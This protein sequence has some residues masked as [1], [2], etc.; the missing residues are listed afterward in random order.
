MNWSWEELNQRARRLNVDRTRAFR[1]LQHIKNVFPDRQAAWET[2][3]YYLSYLEAFLTGMLAPITLGTLPRALSTGKAL[4]GVAITGAVD[5]GRLYLQQTAV[6][7]CAIHFLHNI[8]VCGM[9]GSGKTRLVM[10]LGY[11]CRRGILFDREGE[12]LPLAA[13]RRDIVALHYREGFRHNPFFTLN[14]PAEQREPYL[15]KLAEVISGKAG[16]FDGSHSVLVHAILTLDR[17]GRRQFGPRFVLTLNDL[18]A[19]LRKRV[20][21]GRLSITEKQYHDRVLARLSLLDDEL[22]DVFNTQS[23]MLPYLH[24]RFIILGLA[25]LSDRGAAHLANIIHVFHQFSMPVL[26]HVKFRAARFLDEGHIFASK[27]DSY[28]GENPFA[29]G[30]LR[31]RKRG[32]GNIYCTQNPSLIHE[33]ITNN[34][35][36]RIYFC[37]GST[38]EAEAAARDLFGSDMTSQHVQAIQF[39]PPRFCFIKHPESRVPLLVKVRRVTP[40]T[41]E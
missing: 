28:A 32:C 29:T 36:T 20:M 8:L 37:Q 27:A 9:M 11:Y 30:F 35:R 5:N 10:A 2:V 33:L 19:Y 1:Y 22:G 3:E 15:L 13:A 12:Y 6:T 34:C 31:D 41:I 25:G 26:Q 40:P 18:I 7:L 23:S 16:L 39:L 14:L 21:E 24:D 4:I 38:Q 17:N